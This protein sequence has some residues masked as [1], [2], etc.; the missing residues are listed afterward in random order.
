MLLGLLPA[1]VFAISEA[2]QPAEHLTA[3][4]VGETVYIAGGLTHES[5][6]APYIS[7]GRIMVPVAHA[8]RAL[9]ADVEWDA[10]T[11]TVRVINGTD[12]ISM[13][14]GS[15]ELQQNGAFFMEM[16]TPAVIHKHRK[17]TGTHDAA[18]FAPGQNTGVDYEWDPIQQKPPYFIRPWQTPAPS[19][20]MKRAL[21][22]Q[23]KTMKPLTMT[24]SSVPTASYSKTIPSPAALPS[25]K[26]WAMATSP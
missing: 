19:L 12:T 24:S 26:Q 9:G 4:K 16:E 22:D 15:T 18:G 3:F 8:S 6:V 23:K 25:Q 7:E 5:D 11:R 14:I 21:T 17:R 2:E 13:I 10:E 20:L 1:S